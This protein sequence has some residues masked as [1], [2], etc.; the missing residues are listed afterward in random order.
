MHLLEHKQNVPHPGVFFAGTAIPSM[1]VV[2]ILMSYFHWFVMLSAAKHLGPSNFKGDVLVQPKR[3]TV[4]LTH[5]TPRTL[6][7]TAS[8]ERLTRPSG[9]LWFCDLIAFIVAC[10]QLRAK[11]GSQNYKKQKSHPNKNKHRITP[12]TSPSTFIDVTSYNFTNPPPNE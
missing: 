4:S 5:Q 2:S 10:V 9:F 8:Q 6:H 3:L 1:E 12:F 11:K 7:R